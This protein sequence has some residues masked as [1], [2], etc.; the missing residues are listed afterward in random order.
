MDIRGH[1]AVNRQY[2]WSLSKLSPL[3]RLNK[4]TKCRQTSAI[5]FAFE[6]ETS[7]RFLRTVLVALVS[8]VFRR[9]AQAQNV[10]TAYT[11]PAARTASTTASVQQMRLGEYVSSYERSLR[12]CV[13]KATSFQRKTEVSS[14]SARDVSCNSFQAFGTFARSST[15]RKR[16]LTRFSKTAPIRHSA[17]A[18]CQISNRG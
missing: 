2:T 10:R 18:A 6:R 7:T 1:V 12:P 15:S 8:H 17:V 16:I 9:K 13:H 4:R 14:P 5:M 11:M 3:V